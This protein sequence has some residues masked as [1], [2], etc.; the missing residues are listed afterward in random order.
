MNENPAIARASD[1]EWSVNTES[2]GQPIH[3]G[4]SL[5]A[6]GSTSHGGAS[7]ICPE[8]GCVFLPTR[9]V[10]VRNPA[11]FCSI[12]CSGRNT[13]RI[14]AARNNALRP[15]AGAGNFN[16][17]GWRSRHPVNYVRKFKTQN[18]EKA[19]AHRAVAAAV[20]R[21]ALLRP[22]FCE[23]CL[24]RC[25]PHAHHDDYSMPLVVDWL[26][27]ACHVVADSMRRARLTKK[28]S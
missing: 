21:G 17:K 13:G 22:E 6:E 19:A 28:A 10:T 1:N 26:C 8:C 14:A 24:K 3:R 15:Q 18:P 27:R 9:R 5:P 7:R 16:F 20:R 23:S 2:V 4:D 25:K 12:A 11:R